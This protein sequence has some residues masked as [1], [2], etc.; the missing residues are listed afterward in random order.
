MGARERRCE[1]TERETVPMGQIQ[2]G[3]L[4][5]WIDRRTA[6][7]EESNGRASLSRRGTVISR[8]SAEKPR[9][10]FESRRLSSS[11]WVIRG[12]ETVGWTQPIDMIDDDRAVVRDVNKYIFQD[13]WVRR[14]IKC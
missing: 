5:K 4:R 6:D 11:P 2:K 1:R 13:I 7:L 10:Y 12:V 3:P 14:Q 9:R 8:S